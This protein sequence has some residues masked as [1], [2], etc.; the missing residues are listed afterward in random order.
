[1][2]KV[3]SILNDVIG[4]IMTG[5]SSSHTAACTYI[6]QMTRSLYG[7]EINRAEIIFE[8]TGSYP[9]TY[10]GQ[11]SNYGF[12]GGLLGM[13]PDNPELKNA[14]RISKEQGREIIFRKAALK[15]SHPNGARINILDN[16][17]S[18]EMSVMTYSIGGGM[19]EITE[20]DGF[21]VSIKGEKEKVFILCKSEDLMN[22]LK[23][24]LNQNVFTIIK[25]EGEYLFEMVP[26]TNFNQEYISE[27]IDDPN[28]SFYRVAKQIIPVRREKNS[29]PKFINSR[30]TLEYNKKNNLELWQLAME[31]EMS[32]GEISAEEIFN[33]MQYILEIMK[34]SS[35]PS[36]EQVNIYGFTSP[37]ASV[38]EKKF[39]EKNTVDVGI[40]NEVIIKSTAVMESNCAREIIVAAPTAGSCGVIPGV[41][42][43]IGEKL[44]IDD[45]EIIKSLLVA[46]L[47]GAFIGNLATFSAETGG[48]QAENGSASA[49]AAAAT[50]YLLNGTIEECFKAASL[51]I[52]NL[53]GLICDPIGGLTEIPC[54]NRNAV[55]ASNAL[56]SANMIIAGYDPI[57][58]LDET[59]IAMKRTGERLPRELRCT[60][61]GGLCETETA[62]KIERVLNENRES[63]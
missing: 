11:G 39:R 6:G 18:V 42:L 27:L 38:M 1:M 43:T 41:V 61:L 47:I 37:K 57:I 34:K 32:I 15:E 49:M 2:Q 5:P 44:Q 50:T 20:L 7:K 53:L 60:C 56:I 55:A 22:K 63:L 40:L 29:E 21:P 46:G 4:P 26:D 9:N 3:V 8:E 17:G 36:K 51:A 13:S 33:R 12:I 31:Y 58:P 25:K 10:I 52:Q 28:I 23:K 24:T 30:E 16:E 14:I 45:K 19:F 48:C 35:I 59:I 54:I 62:I